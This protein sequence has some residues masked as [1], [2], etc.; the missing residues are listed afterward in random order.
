M[1]TNNATTTMDL[2]RVHGESISDVTA[3]AKTV[4]Y[5]QVAHLLG[6]QMPFTSAEVASAGQVPI[7]SR[8][9]HIEHSV[10]D[11]NF[12]GAAEPGRIILVANSVSGTR[13]FLTKIPENLDYANLV[14]E[15]KPTVTIP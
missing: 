7:H 4:D 14:G 3:F 15:P 2:V 13:V 8:F 9:L 6:F 11:R 12:S 1:I 10:T 5:T